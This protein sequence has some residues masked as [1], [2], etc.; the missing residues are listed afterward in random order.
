ML[1]QP[2]L[3]FVMVAILDSCVAQETI[4]STFRQYVIVLFLHESKFNKN[5]VI[6]GVGC[7]PKAGFVIFVTCILISVKTILFMRII[8]MRIMRLSTF[9]MLRNGII[10]YCFSKQHNRKKLCLT[11]IFILFCKSVTDNPTTLLRFCNWQS[12]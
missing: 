1:E 11:K 8:E 6:Y 2:T 12:T 7:E 3:L 5:T 10:T 9:R 4:E